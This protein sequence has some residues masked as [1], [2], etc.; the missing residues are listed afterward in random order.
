M[1]NIERQLFLPKPGTETFFLW[2]ARQSGQS[3]LLRQI[4]PEVPWIDLLKADVLR[5]YATAPRRFLTGVAAVYDRRCLSL[6]WFW[7][8]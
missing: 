1:A 3:T 5:R 6:E 7:C 4:Y 2:G 8:S